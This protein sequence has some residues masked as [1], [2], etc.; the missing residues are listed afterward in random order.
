MAKFY[1]V[2]VGAG[3]GSY[4]TLGALRAL[5]KS[6]IIA[7]PSKKSGNKSTALNIISKEFDTSKKELLEL[8]FSMSS[9]AKERELSREKSAERIIAAL[10]AGKNVAMIT[11]GDVSIYSTCSYVHGAVKNAGFEIEIIPGITSF[12]AAADKARISLCEGGESV[13]IIPSAKGADLEKYTADFDT[14]IIMKA[15]ADTDGIYEALKRRGM[16]SNAIVS[17][18]VG[19]ENE[20]IEPLREGKSYGYFTTVIIKKKG[21]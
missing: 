21:F 3:D 6:D 10:K 13:A 19:M 16:E 8:E 15:G 7:V 4:I 18:R 11:L 5:E 20:L 14:V 2:G 12:C 9:D 17:S 1:S